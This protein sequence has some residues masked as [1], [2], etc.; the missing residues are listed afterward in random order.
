MLL[1]VSYTGYGLSYLQQ[2]MPGLRFVER[3]GLPPHAALPRRYVPQELAL[4]VSTAGFT[5][6]DGQV[7][8]TETTALYLR[9]TKE[10]LA[11]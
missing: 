5:P 11:P 6:S 8:G 10:R 4:L 7:L 2:L 3:F 1:V 9:A